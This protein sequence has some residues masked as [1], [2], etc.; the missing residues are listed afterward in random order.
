M[1]SITEIIEFL[2]KWQTLIGSLVGGFFALC[3]AIIVGNALRR[4][5]DISSGMLLLHDLANVRS[6]FQAITEVAKKKNINEKAYPFW[7]A[8]QLMEHYPKLSPLFTSSVLRVLPI[9]HDLA[10]HLNSFYQI[11]TEIEIIVSG[12]SEDFKAIKKEGNS[13][14][15]T[16]RILHNVSIVNEFFPIIAQHALCAEL[17]I[18]HLI[19]SK[20]P[21]F[22]KLRHYFWAKLFDKVCMDYLK[23]EPHTIKNSSKEE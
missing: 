2:N 17:L 21:T 11:Y 12:L 22:N 9:S 7:F 1:A 18:R 8:G 16:T 23:R 20:F 15:L 4:R 14:I 10:S 6:S 13:D 3:V 5:E 19:L